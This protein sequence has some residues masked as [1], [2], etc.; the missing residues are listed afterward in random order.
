VVEVGILNVQEY[1]MKKKEVEKKEILT[2][3]LLLDQ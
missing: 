2:L 3:L 1:G